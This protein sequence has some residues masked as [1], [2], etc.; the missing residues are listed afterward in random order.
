MSSTDNLKGNVASGLQDFTVGI[1]A[2]NGDFYDISNNITELSFYESIYRPYIHGDLA[3]IDNSMMLTDFPFIGQERAV[4]SWKRD[5]QLLSKVFYITKV[6]N[7]AR[8]LDGVGVYE[9]NL[10][11][12][13]QTRNS[14][15]LFS[16]S[17]RGRSDEI[18]T[19]VF[20]EHLGTTITPIDGTTGKTSHNVVFPYMKPL[21]AVDM[22]Q[23]NV[24]ADDN[25][26]MFVYDTFY[27]NEIRLDSFA[28]MYARKPITTIESRKPVNR[29]K[30]GQVSREYLDDRGMVFDESISRA[31]DM[32]DSLNKGVFGSTV[33]ITDSSIRQ[34]DKVE[35]DYKRDAPPLAKDWVSPEFV[36]EGDA[37]NAKVN[38]RNLYLHRNALAY[39]D[40]Y[41][42]LNTIEDLDRSI[43]NSYVRRHATTLVKVYM[44]SIAYTLEND[45]PFTVGQ[46]VDYNIVKFMPQLSEAEEEKDLVN[47][48]KY[49]VS[50]IRHFIKNYEYTMSVELVR[51][52]VGPRAEI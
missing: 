25:T 27:P 22:I 2:H 38:T 43:L 36:V 18:I 8:Q 23:K 5:D 20:D 33:T 17:Y 28:R 6:S 39:N 16:Q 47:S 13:V 21:Q 44:D 46:T 24:L 31:Y 10:N 1:V 51:D 29:D 26:P 7:V 42:N 32:Y 41:P 34:Y 15:N 48:G 52:G 4:I 14:I 40:D 49:I 19:Q 37:P 3:I 45:E 9:M 30:D 35:F 12:V 50:A 11:S